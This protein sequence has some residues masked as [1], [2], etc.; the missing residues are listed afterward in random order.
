MSPIPAPPDQRRGEDSDLSTRGPFGRQTEEYD[1]GGQTKLDQTAS[2]GMT[3][4][5]FGMIDTSQ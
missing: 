2:A 4:R 3:K 1:N 5:T